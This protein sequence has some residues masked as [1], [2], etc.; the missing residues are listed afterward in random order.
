MQEKLIQSW[1]DLFPPAEVEEY[2]LH[3]PEERSNYFMK[4]WDEWVSTNIDLRKYTPKHSIDL[5]SHRY[6]WYQ[7]DVARQF[8]HEQGLKEFW[9]YQVRGDE[10]RFKD[11][12]MA[13]LFRLT[14]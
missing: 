14:L 13:L 1:D 12:D 11:D 6:N 5:A 3:T 8:A 9:D 2:G 4:L 10:V 7:N